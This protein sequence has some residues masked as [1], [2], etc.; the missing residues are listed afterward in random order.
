ME[1]EGYV[2][3]SFAES[4]LISQWLV[5]CAATLEDT[6]SLQPLAKPEEVLQLA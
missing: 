4:C 6:A 3:D 1:G 5:L 2:Y